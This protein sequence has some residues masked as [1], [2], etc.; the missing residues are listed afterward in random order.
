MSREG[1]V[2]EGEEGYYPELAVCY[3]IIIQPIYTMYLI[4]DWH[5]GGLRKASS[6]RVR[7]S[8]QREFEPSPERGPARCPNSFFAV[9]FLPF[10]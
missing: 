10:L 6:L 2:G 9:D 7:D 5:G 3:L 4:L 8:C 1:R